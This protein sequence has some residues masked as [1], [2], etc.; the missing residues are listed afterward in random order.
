MREGAP[1]HFDGD[2]KD[3]G[4]RTGRAAEWPA[5]ARDVCREGAPEPAQ[6]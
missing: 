4:S 1:P 3:R 2:A 6:A 5:N